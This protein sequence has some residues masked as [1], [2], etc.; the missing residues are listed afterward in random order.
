M[1]KFFRRIR[2][3]L[4]ERE[5]F[6][7]YIFYALGEILLVVIGILIALQVNNW[8]EERK[9]QKRVDMA[10]ERLFHESQEIVLYF[11]NENGWIQ[12]FTNDLDATTK[13]LHDGSFRE[14]PAD[15]IITGV[16]LYPTPWPPKNVYDELT[17]AGEFK[18][19]E[20]EEVRN[21]VVDYYRS[22]TFLE[23]QIQYF[24]TIQ[25]NLDDLAGDAISST[26]NE[27][28][29]NRLQ[30]VR[31]L[32]ALSNNQE[33]KSALLNGLRDMLQMQRFRNIVLNSAIDM[34]T[35]IGQ[36]IQKEC[37]AVDQEI[38]VQIPTL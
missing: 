35:A 16:G 5:K 12:E 23:G 14:L 3:K 32:E 37:T 13:A 1:L 19:I 33:F 20:S 7:K 9:Q 31:N 17:N 4:I 36:S 24:R 30:I 11:R 25:Y 6:R 26:Y 34:C 8:N 2:K 29:P 10:L 27:N 15:R 21:T 18:E 22:L 28:Y 38:D